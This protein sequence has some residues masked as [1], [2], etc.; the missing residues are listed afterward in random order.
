MVI[1]RIPEARIVTRD[2]LFVNCK[3]LKEIKNASSQMFNQNDIRDH[4]ILQ[5]NC[6]K[7]LLQK[8]RVFLIR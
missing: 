4:K 7:K 2:D 6:S 5:K 3:K 1:I 8:Y